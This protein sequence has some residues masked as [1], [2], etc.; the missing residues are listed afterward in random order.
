[1][2][3]TNQFTPQTLTG[4]CRHCGN[5]RIDPNT[6]RVFGDNDDCVPCCS[7]CRSALCHEY[8]SDARAIKAFYNGRG[9]FVGADR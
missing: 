6:A 7:E 1:M 2:A 9:F 8:E 3:A 5:D 4:I